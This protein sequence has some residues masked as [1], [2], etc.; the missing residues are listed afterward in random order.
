MIINIYIVCFSSCYLEEIQQKNF[1][2]IIQMFI[3]SLTL[4]ENFNYYTSFTK[5]ILILFADT[6]LT[7][8]HCLLT[9][10]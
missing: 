4:A 8:N 3:S 1:L 7:Q 5:N 6:S 10:Y 2:L 9:D